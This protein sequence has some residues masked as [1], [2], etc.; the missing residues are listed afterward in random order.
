MSTETLKISLAQKILGISDDLLLN[1]LKTLIES[2]NIVGYAK[3]KPI[4]ESQYIKEM[5]KSIMAI[6]NGTATL[7][8]TKE[9]RNNILNENNL[10]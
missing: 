1:K 7:Y 10:G 6:K 2:E 8:T 9:V 4:Y 5:N 3:G